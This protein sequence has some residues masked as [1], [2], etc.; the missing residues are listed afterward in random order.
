MRLLPIQLLTWCGETQVLLTSRFS[1]VRRSALLGP[2]ALLPLVALVAAVSPAPAALG[3]EAIAPP[4]LPAP[5]QDDAGT[6]AV[7]D[8]VQAELSR[9]GDDL[10]RVEVL[11]DS[12]VVE[13]DA[14]R[15]ASP[16]EQQLARVRADQ[17]VRQIRN[18]VTRLL[19]VIPT[20]QAAGAAVDSVR[21]GLGTF[22]VRVGGLYDEAIERRMAEIDDFRDARASSPPDSLAALEA[23]VRETKAIL[24][25]LLVERVQNLSRADSLG[26]DTSEQWQT[27]E[28]TLTS[29]A[30]SQVGRLQI[31]LLNRNRLSEQIR[32]AEEA[33]SAPNEITA[34]RT[35]LR[36]TEDRIE[37]ITATLGVTADLLAGRGFETAAY[38]QMIIRGTG[39]VTAD[40]L[41]PEVLI[42][43]LGDL[44]NGLWNWLKSNGPTLFV[45]FLIVLGVIILFRVAFRVGWWLFR[46]LRLVRLSK[47]MTD[48]IGR[49]LRPIATIIGLA[50]GLWLV[51]VDP[52]TLL[53]GLGVAGVIVGLA[54][55]DSMSNLA[56]G[57]FILATRPFDVED[58][59][60]AGG[61][62]GTVQEMGLANTTILTF[63]R[64]R[65]FVPN[66]QIWSHVIENRSA[67]PV[68]R[69]EVTARISY[70]EDLDR[71]VALLQSILDE[72]EMVL[73]DPEPVV[74][75][76]TLADSWIEIAVWPWAE[77]ENWLELTRSLPRLIRLRFAREGIE[78]PHT[79]IELVADRPD[80]GPSAPATT[81]P[82]D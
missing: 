67:E 64:R 1:T 49:M 76:Q 39:D 5:A 66:R 81:E 2:T 11:L 56:A 33:R 41:D 75:V 79:R 60:E 15:D 69:V 36:A 20:L 48:L 27:I 43:L 51:G 71:A 52:T 70:R 31:A 14:V 26:L 35:R 13:W 82:A 7:S 32:Q 78:V 62:V 55:Q 40:I 73:A 58:V 65:L 8:S 77:T 63:D 21:Q 50:T 72:N 42:G 80:S 34:L 38:R 28:R 46:V 47:L 22:L 3:N 24:D 53:A 59:V 17:G 37:G 9:A 19:Q 23:R 6:Q 30:E 18:T 45:R 74:F 12:I 25:T 54:L 4:G 29:W 10:A 57:L 16:E 61:V 44:A 68:R